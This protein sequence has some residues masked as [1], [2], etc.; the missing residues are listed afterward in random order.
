ME[1]SEGEQPLESPPAASD[2]VFEPQIQ[3]DGPDADLASA[4]N[5]A[6]PFEVPPEPNEE[7]KSNSE[8]TEAAESTHAESAQEG[9]SEIVLNQEGSI[10]AA[11]GAPEEPEAQPD[12]PAQDLGT[13]LSDLGNKSLEDEKPKAPKELEIENLESI[14]VEEEAL[15]GEGESLAE[16]SE[17]VPEADSP[18][19][20]DNKDPNL[21]QEE[22]SNLHSEG[23]VDVIESE[24]ESSLSDEAETGPDLGGLEVSSSETESAQA[25]AGLVDEPEMVSLEEDS[26][27]SLVE[28]IAELSD[29]GSAETLNE[30]EIS[31]ADPAEEPE[32]IEES[33]QVTEGGEGEDMPLKPAA[34]V[35]A[36]AIEEVETEEI[37][38]AL[39]E[40]DRLESSA[41]EIEEQVEKLG[42][43]VDIA[44]IPKSK[45]KRVLKKAEGIDS[46]VPKAKPKTRKKTQKRQASESSTKH[47]QPKKRISLLDSYFKD[48]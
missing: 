48:L 10:E 8:E 2:P 30:A 40:G 45:P 19:S 26:E 47:S 22:Q 16:I 29:A 1:F 34:D 7:T 39:Q 25:P 43:V 4:A 3:D 23:A 9:L 13:E 46:D 35:V 11:L 5:E 14:E 31:A 15:T 28:E 37:E 36:E 41:S 44:S 27:G 24:V 18:E 20:T 42:K 32:S 17:A 38:E 21:N 33:P 12:S 6:T